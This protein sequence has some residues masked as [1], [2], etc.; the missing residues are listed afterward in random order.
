MQEDRQ[1]GSAES[2]FLHPAAAVRAA[3]IHE[4]M[5]VADFGAGSGFFTRAAARAVG[6]ESRVWAVDT[7]Q[8]MLGHIKS[9]AL[10][11]GLKNVEVVRGNI[12]AEGGSHLPPEHM[13]FVIAANV[14]FSATDKKA[15]AKEIRRV[16]KRTGRALIIDWSSSHGGLGPH[17]AHVV[18]EREART[19]FE[20]AGFTYV[21]AVPCGAYHWGFVARKK[22][23]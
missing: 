6:P 15:L 11:E 22:M 21:E 10:A 3:K 16:L 19:I 14:L 7:N 12:E 5:E 18:T 9:L 8:D 13:D 20:E 2:S 4:G 17:E 23:Q 1:E